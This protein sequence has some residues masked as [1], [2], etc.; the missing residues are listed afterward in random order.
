MRAFADS[1]GTAYLLYRAATNKVNRDM[2]LLSSSDAGKSFKGTLIH[3]MQTDICPMSSESF[4]EGAGNVYCAWETEGQVFFASINPPGI[5]VKALALGKQ[6]KH[7][8]L[9]VNRDGEVL[10]AWAEGT[11]W[12]RGGDLAWQLFDKTGRPTTD[13]GR[14]ANGIPTWSLPTAVVGN[15]GRLTIV[16]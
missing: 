10:L 8:A 7:P 5:P 3:K 16:H 13:R 6:C 12:Q 1:K 2:I 4:A 9:A 14:V 15:D 11:G